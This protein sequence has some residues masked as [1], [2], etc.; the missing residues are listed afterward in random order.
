MWYT[1]TACVVAVVA[2]VAVVT[3]VT[4]VTVYDMIYACSAQMQE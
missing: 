1:V 2:V 3:V 4:V